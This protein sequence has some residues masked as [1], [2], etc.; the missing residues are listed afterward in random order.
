M[1]FRMFVIVILILASLL[2]SYDRV[3][4]TYIYLNDT[5]GADVKIEERVYNGD[6]A[7]IYTLHSDQ[8]GKY[9]DVKKEF[10]KDISEQ[11]Y[12]LYGTT[13]V[14]NKIRIVNTSTRGGFKR[15]VIFHVSGIYK[16]STCGFNKIFVFSR[17]H[18]RL[19]A[20]LQRYFES[21]IDGKFFESTFVS[22]ASRKNLDTFK[23]THIYLPRGSKFVS[24]RPVFSKKVLFSW[25]RD[26]GKGN[27]LAGGIKIKGNEIVV[28]EEEITSREAPDP[29][30]SG[31]NEWFFDLLRDI[32]AF[33]LRF[34]NRKIN[35]KH[36][37]KPVRYNPKWDFSKGWS[38]NF[39]VGKSYKFCS[40][41]VCLTPGI[42][43]GTNFKVH[44]KWEHKWVRHGWHFRYEFKKFEGKITIN[45]YTKLSV[46]LNAGSSKSKSWSKTLIR[47]NRWFTFWVSGTP[48]VI[49]LEGT[50][51]A[52]ASVG[53]SGSITESVYTRFDIYTNVTFKYQGGW[54]R[55][56][57]KSYS[58]SGVNFSANAKVNA[59][60]KGELPVTFSGY[61]YDISGPYV[62]LTPWIKG[63]ANA[64][65]GS[66][67]NQVGYSVTG[68]LKLTGG[69]QMAGWLKSLCGNIG[70]KSY[71][72]WSKTWTLKSGTYTF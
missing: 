2:F 44:I 71:T 19:T 11:F 55:S 16:C 7:K 41:N 43:A 12:L 57:S 35:S 13:E 3:I 72:L 23:V 69:V 32:G 66:A 30:V 46:K 22:S 61:V 6:L 50:V 70:S 53:V 27:V 60:A 59:W 63:Q 17:K 58:Y 62:R 29:I 10:L 51:K 24:L 52:N 68:G 54:S 36:L 42:T 8:L 33:D 15:T 38:H 65:A 34:A 9:S 64:S 48:V 4:N 45:P 20:D 37:T 28:E 5:G 18:Y 39:S 49:V 47:K 40:G 56:F 21:F 14:P 67:Q 1:Q 25:K 31:K 26:Y